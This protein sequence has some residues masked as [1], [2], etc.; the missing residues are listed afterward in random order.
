MLFT[1][2]AKYCPVSKLFA[3]FYD[4]LLILTFII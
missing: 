2:E 1:Q 3:I 4:R